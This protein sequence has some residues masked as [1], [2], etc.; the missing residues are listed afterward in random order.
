MRRRPL[1]DAEIG[2]LPR[3]YSGFAAGVL[4]PTGPPTVLLTGLPHRN[5]VADSRTN[6]WIKSWVGAF[7]GGDE[8]FLFL[9]SLYI[10]IEFTDRTCDNVA[11]L[12]FLNDHFAGFHHGAAVQFWHPRRPQQ[13]FGNLVLTHTCLQ[14]RA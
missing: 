6:M 13:A 9:A 12:E 8:I 2:P 1:T 3:Y 11:R 7:S 5:D 4:L 14:R 10:R